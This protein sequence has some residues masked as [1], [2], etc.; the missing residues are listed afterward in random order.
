MENNSVMNLAR[1][2]N[3]ISA[4]RKTFD[5]DLSGLTV[6]TEAASG[7]FALTPLIAAL[8]GAHEVIAIGKDSRYGKFAEIKDFISNLS[9]EAN[10]LGKIRFV[11]Q[12]RSDDVSRAD[13]VT[14]LGFVRPID[15]KMISWMRA[16]AVIPLMWEPWE[17]RCGDLD[18]TACERR[19]IPVLGTDERSKDL[20]TME[21][22]ALLT[23]K[24]L[25][26]AD[27]EIL[28]SKVMVLGSG[29]FG[30]CTAET[31]YRLGA[32][33]AWFTPGDGG[34]LNGCQ[35]PLGVSIFQTFEEQSCLD[36]IAECDALVMVEHRTKKMMIGPGGHF[37]FTRL[38]E[39][40]KGIVV[41]HICG[42]I[43]TAELTDS[44]LR[45]RPQGIRPA[46]YMSL[47]TAYL[48]PR[49]LIDLHTAGLRVGQVLAEARLDGKGICEA[50]ESAIRLAPGKDFS[51]VACST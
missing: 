27:I 23:V 44:G 5:L 14:N 20:R 49:P 34:P 25:L 16:T 7:Y 21:F 2:L 37:S 36:F 3:L 40:N 50:K 6:F 18:L 29:P 10:C 11:N 17:F 15:D 31:L 32:N 19:G 47:T 41:I 4:A 35:Q 1:S 43:D 33:V 12:K 30:R 24:L 51:T 8:A 28:L 42:E 22:V 9:D 39:L 45:F 26:E 13:I 48:G 38:A 46:G